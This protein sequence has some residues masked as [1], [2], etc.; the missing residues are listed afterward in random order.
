MLQRKKLRSRNNGVPNC[1]GVPESWSFLVEIEEF[2]F[3]EK[4]NAEKKRPIQNNFLF[5][6][7]FSMQ[8]Y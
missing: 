7:R 1:P 8:F 2:K 6:Y 4:N 5:I 3:L